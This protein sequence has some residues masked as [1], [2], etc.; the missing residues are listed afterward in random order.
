[1]ILFGSLKKM[2]KVHD[3]FRINLKIYKNMVARILVASY[4]SLKL[5]QSLIS[6]S[7]TRFQMAGC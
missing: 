1:M 2:F 7:E 5:N 6:N 3:F 4:N